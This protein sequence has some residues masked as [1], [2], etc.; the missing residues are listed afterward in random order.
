MHVP[1][2]MW[3]VI[4]DAEA[5]SPQVAS[6]LRRSGVRYVHLIGKEEAVFILLFMSFV[7]VIFPLCLYIFV[8]IA[9][10][11]PKYQPGLLFQVATA[12]LGGFVPKD[13]LTVCGSTRKL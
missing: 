4:E 5:L 6:L 7:N 12:F 13:P 9:F 10:F 2:I 8:M 11:K 3:L 1:S